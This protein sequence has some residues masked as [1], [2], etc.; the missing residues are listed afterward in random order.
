MGSDAVD[1]GIF[2]WDWGGDA[3]VVSLGDFSRCGE[4]SFSDAGMVVA[5]LSFVTEG[6][7]N[8]FPMFIVF[9]F[10]DEVNVDVV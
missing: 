5:V 6:D 3:N 9:P 7:G 10:D 2:T 4:K 1:G 8:E